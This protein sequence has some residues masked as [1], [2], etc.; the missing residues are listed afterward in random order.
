MTFFVMN[1]D[2]DPDVP[3]I[4]R[5][6]FLATVGVK[7][8]VKAGKLSLSVGDEKLEFRLQVAMKI[9]MTRKIQIKESLRFGSG[10]K[11]KMCPRKRPEA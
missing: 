8:D 2:E 1:M 3:I 5:R 10:H 4:L 6:P 7:I 11:C 9:P